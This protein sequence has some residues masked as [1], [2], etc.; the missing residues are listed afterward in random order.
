[1]T[2]VICMLTLMNNSGMPEQVQAKG[3]IVDDFKETWIVDI[4]DYIQEHPR[5]KQFNNLVVEVNNNEC[6]YISKV[7]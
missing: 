7:R 1:M 6:A 5:F 4:T 3:F 2:W